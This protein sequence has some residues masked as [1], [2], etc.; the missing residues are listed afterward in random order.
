M[1]PA[2]E[3]MGGATSGLELELGRGASAFKGAACGIA[4]GIGGG[5]MLTDFLAG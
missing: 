3:E 1:N 2:G 5:S 4:V